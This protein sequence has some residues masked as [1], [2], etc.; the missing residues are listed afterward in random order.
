MRVVGRY[1]RK[2]QI[3]KRIAAGDSA[4]SRSQWR[5]AASAYHEALQFDPNLGH[6]WVQYGHAL[7]EQGRVTEAEHAYRRSI[8]LDSEVADTHLQLGHA[9][10]LQHRMD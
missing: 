5:L 3:A 6:I 8:T 2:V 10:K 1:S 9:L 4:R 7:K